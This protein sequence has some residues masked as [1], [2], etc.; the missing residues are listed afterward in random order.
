VPSVWLET[1][2]QV[3][4]EAMA[5][6]VPVVTF[7]AGASPDINIS[8][9]TG[10]VVPAKNSPALA[11]AIIK[12]LSDDNLRL[13]YGQ[14]ARERVLANYTYEVVINKLIT[15]INRAKDAVGKR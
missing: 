12:I 3:T 10:L 13:N 7:D 5:C 2:G 11:E 14:A 4:I 1:F 8:G 6:G 9:Q 15:I